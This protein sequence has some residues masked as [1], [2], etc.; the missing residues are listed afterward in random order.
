VVL[1]VVKRNYKETTP[2]DEEISK[3]KIL[4]RDFFVD[5]HELR[6]HAETGEDDWE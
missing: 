3:S 2:R 6:K 5:K 4:R 1:K